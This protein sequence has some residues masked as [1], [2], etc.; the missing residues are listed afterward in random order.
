MGYVGDG[1]QRLL[2]RVLAHDP[3]TG[4]PTRVLAARAVAGLTLQLGVPE[5][6]SRILTYRVLAP[7]HGECRLIV[8]AG[9]TGIRT[10]A[11]VLGFAIFR[12]GQYGWRDNQRN[13]Y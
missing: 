8:V 5:W 4:G 7:K 13:Q 2:E 3:D 6:G 1:V 10:L 9:E 11:T 12:L